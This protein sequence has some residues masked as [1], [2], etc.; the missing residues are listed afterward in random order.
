[1][2]FLSIERVSKY[3]PMLEGASTRAGRQALFCVFKDVDF[4][5]SRRESLSPS[6]AILAVVRVL[7]ST[8]SPVSSKPPLEASF[9]TAKK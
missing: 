7:Y 8:L 3:F 6:L 1:M 4:T 5:V 9:S 2:A